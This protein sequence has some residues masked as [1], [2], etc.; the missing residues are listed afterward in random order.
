MCQAALEVSEQKSKIEEVGFRVYKLLF[1]MT[2][3]IN[4]T[5]KIQEGISSYIA[6][7]QK[8]TPSSHQLRI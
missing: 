3:V 7:P 5:P 1:S 4:L 6:C 8:A 2:R